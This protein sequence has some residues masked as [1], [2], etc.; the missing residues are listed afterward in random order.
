M[1]VGAVAFVN[2]NDRSVVVFVADYAADGLVYAHLGQVVV[3]VPPWIICPLTM[4]F[5]QLNLYVSYISIRNPNN[6]HSPTKMMLEI[7]PF[8]KLSL[9]NT[10]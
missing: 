8:R 1:P 5:L 10:Q 7:Q 6:H 4:T 3:V 9:T 2:Q